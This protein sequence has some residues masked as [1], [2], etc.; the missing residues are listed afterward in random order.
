MRKSVSKQLKK[1]V[2]SFMGEKNINKSYFKRIYRR[3]KK[4]YNQGMWD[5]DR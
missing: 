1:D 5:A 3:A 4:D 2:S